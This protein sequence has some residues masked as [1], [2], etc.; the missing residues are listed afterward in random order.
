MQEDENEKKKEIHSELE[1][2]HKKIEIITKEA[3]KLLE[4]YKGA[5][6]EKNLGIFQHEAEE[7]E[8]KVQRVKTGIKGLDELM[9]GGVPEKSLILLT[10]TTGTG[11]SIF[12]ME[13]LVEGAINNE[14]GVYISLQESMEETMNQMRFFGWPVDKLVEDGKLLIVQPELY[15][16]DALLTAIE[17][18]IDKVNAK[19]L[20][21]D[22][23]SI[24]GM[25]FEKKFKI[26]KSLLEIAQL[27]KKMDCT[28]IA[29]SE[30]GEGEVELSPFGIE[31]YIADAV[32]ILYYAKKGSAFIRAMTI[33]K[34]RA[35]KHSTKIHP[36][37]IRRSEGIV[38]YPTEEV[39]STVW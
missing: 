39:F 5:E 21:I 18:A 27:L 34:M 11:K 16:F 15:N 13:F 33:R 4:R 24:I 36:I 17:D 35:T 14:P 26:R 20:V 32:I 19:R 38:V 28:C 1:E 12:A 37:E 10:G 7:A 31:E 2:H 3:N 29:I 9:E 22:S 25:Y 30:I 23:I 8:H 6:P